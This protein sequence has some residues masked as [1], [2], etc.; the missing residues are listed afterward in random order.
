M[1]P[2]SCPCALGDADGPCLHPFQTHIHEPLSSFFPC[3][4][5]LWKS[6]RGQKSP[7]LRSLFM[8]MWLLLLTCWYVGPMAGCGGQFS[9]LVHA[10]PMLAVG[11]PFLLSW[12]TEQTEELFGKCVGGPLGVPNLAADG[13]KCCPVTPDLVAIVALAALYPGRVWFPVLSIRGAQGSQSCRYSRL[14]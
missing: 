3:L 1:S 10:V 8:R 6:R 4:S 7:I 2:L 14:V 12:S 11:G 9:L 5:D 13:R